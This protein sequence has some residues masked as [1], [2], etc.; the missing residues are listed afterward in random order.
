MARSRRP[1]RLAVLL[2]ELTLAWLVLAPRYSPELSGPC[3]VE[4]QVLIER[5]GPQGTSA[6]AESYRTGWVHQQDPQAV[7]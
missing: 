7:T 2:T 3:G 1:N 5:I 6:G 4:A